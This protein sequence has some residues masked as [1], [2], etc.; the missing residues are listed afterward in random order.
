MT[1]DPADKSLLRCTIMKSVD[2]FA[3]LV[4]YASYVVCGATALGLAVY[5]AMALYSIAVEPIQAFLA[6]ALGGITFAGLLAAMVPW[7]VYVGIAAVAAIPVYSLLWCIAREL[8]E[9]DWDFSEPYKRDV[10][11]YEIILRIVT[12]PI[13]IVEGIMNPEGKSPKTR[14]VVFFIGAYL[15][16]RKRMKEERK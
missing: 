14:K 9:E 5:G 4:L 10:S 12:I 3:K 7:Y 1:T 2:V 8:T 13:A 6:Y 16:Y 11:W 15:H